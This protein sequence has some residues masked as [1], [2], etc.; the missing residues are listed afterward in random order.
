[1]SKTCREINELTPTAQ[2]ACR[3]FL[4]KCEEA[5]LNIFITETYR[6]QERQNELYAQGRT[7]PGKIVTWTLNS[8]HTSRRAWDIAVNGPV[9]YDM[10]VIRKAGEIGKQLGITWGGI[11]SPPDYA[12]FEVT[13]DWKAPEEV[14]EV[15][16][17]QFNQMM[18]VYLAERNK[19]PVSDWAKNDVE[20]AKAVGITDGTMPQGLATREQV[21]S[22]IARA[23]EKKE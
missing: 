16:Q 17:E 23:M 2:R 14:E 11:W 15:T 20:K 12:H 21:V 7:E 5:G 4:K 18:E 8:R 19:K 10:S 22:M 1:M 6:S 13:N 3:L 9:L